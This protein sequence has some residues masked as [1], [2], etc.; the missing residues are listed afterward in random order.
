MI[1]NLLMKDLI[2]HYKLPHTNITSLHLQDRHFELD[3]IKGQGLT[4]V[5]TG[6]AKFSNPEQLEITIIDYERFINAINNPIFQKDRGRCD[7][8]CT[9]DDYFVLGELK[10]AKSRN[11][12]DRRKEAKQQLL[13]SLKT[14]NEVP[15]IATFISAK[16]KKCCCF[17]YKKP[18][19]IA[20]LSAVSAFN[21]INTYTNGLKG[22]A[23]HITALG[24]EFY[25]YKNDN[26]FTFNALNIINH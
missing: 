1:E 3:D 11:I 7:L 9:A 19:D 5:S 8:C 6:T 14:L 18:S 12:K 10:T 2:A 13:A 21:R 23:T 17:F 4:L 16:R 22:E 26:V 25:E 24:F 15:Q 20:S